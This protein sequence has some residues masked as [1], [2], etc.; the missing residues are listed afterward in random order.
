MVEVPCLHHLWDGQK[1]HHNNEKVIWCI[2]SSIACISCFY[3]AYDSLTTLGLPI[4]ELVGFL[5]RQQPMLHV[6][7]SPIVL[8]GR[9]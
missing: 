1:D 9:I 7:V 6:E 2:G 3:K 5:Y 4:R 8:L